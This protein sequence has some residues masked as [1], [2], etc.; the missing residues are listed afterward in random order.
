MA[1]IEKKDEKSKKTIIVG[2][3]LDLGLIYETLF[4]E[5]VPST[6]EPPKLFLQVA[7]QTV[8]NNQPHQRLHQQIYQISSHQR[9]H[10]QL[11][12]ISSH[13]LHQ[14]LCQTP[15]HQQLDQI[16]SHH[17]TNN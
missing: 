16:C 4:T 1:D 11:D 5:H 6:G 3:Q 15:S 17:H 8:S 9:L 10:Q 13:R 2:R 12:Q 14:Q 7:K